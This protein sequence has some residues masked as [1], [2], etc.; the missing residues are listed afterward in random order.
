MK[1]KPLFS[2]SLGVR[3]MATY[4]ETPGCKI[5]IDPSAA[6][7][8]VR[9]GLPPSPEEFEALQN[10][11]QEIHKIAKECD[12]LT[13]SHYHY[14][15]YDPTENFYAGKTVYAKDIRASINKSQAHRGKDFELLV[16]EKCNLIYSDGREFQHGKTKIKFSM[17]TP[18][19]PAGIVLGYV[20]MTII[21][22]GGKKVLHA[23]DAQGPVVA[24][25]AEY[26]I[27]ENPDV[28]IIDGPP[29]LFLGWKFSMK[30]LEDAQDN[31]LRI[32]KETSAEIILD[33]HLLRDLKYKE[34]FAKVYATGRPKT[35]AEYA[36]K[37]NTMLEAHRKELWAKIQNRD[38]MLEKMRTAAGEE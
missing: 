37:E 2:D 12:V 35:F 15:H 31:M 11:K 8:P 38:E 32:I 16:K 7:G 33:H 18:H 29:T 20:L 6:L 36:G 19:G 24:E 21:E 23:S 34:R 1:V 17:P 4:V 9:Y 22:S 26:I 13:I 5:L 25:A 10:A 28:L 27:K 3:S 30:N 14:D